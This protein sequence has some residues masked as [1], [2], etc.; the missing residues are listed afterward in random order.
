MSTKPGSEGGAASSAPLRVLHLH[1]TFD[2]GGKERRA[3]AL[4]NAFARDGKGKAIRHSIVSAVPEAT[5]ARAAIDP[6]VTVNFPFGFP[7]LTGKFSVDRLRKLARAMQDFD[8]V[9]TYNWG[10][11]DAAMA[12]AMF[13]P[14]MKLPPLV[15]HEDGFNADEA[16]KLSRRRNWYRTVALARAS[17]L[18]VPSERLE[19]IALTA[20]RQPRGKV[21]RIAN[22]IDTAAFTAQPG[23][24]P[25][26]PKAIPR[27]VKR[28]DEIWI[29]SV[30]GLRAVKALP[31]MV[32]AFSVLDDRFQLVILGEGPERQAIMQKAIDLEIGHRVH[33]PGFVADP[34]GTIGLFDIFALSSDSE[35]FPLSVVEA[36]AAGLPVASPAV[37]DVALM[38][39]PEN[40]PYIVAPG[41]AEALGAA[42]QELGDSATLRATIG[43]A[44][45]ARARAEYDAGPM[46]ARYAELYAGVLNRASFP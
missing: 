30:A 25:L 34:A 23:Q 12:H 5:G 22:G 4:M 26:N 43:E 8:L 6:A 29:G 38:V 36:M 44:N 16:G 20:W 37:G 31:R 11:M 15:H 19:A 9:L 28:A 46:V 27:V 2:A 10:A 13:A 1:S 24:K 21:V 3:V 14:S 33:L 18:V 39:A 41:D 32:E 17:R 42:M 35:Q 45:R 40:L 7:P